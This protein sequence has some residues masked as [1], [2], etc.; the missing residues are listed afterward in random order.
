M[1][2]NESNSRDLE[3]DEVK[4]FSQEG[5]CFIF[6]SVNGVI[7]SVE[8]KSDKIIRIRYAPESVFERD[9]SYAIDD[10]FEGQL[11]EL[12]FKEKDDH[13]RITTERLIVRI[14]KDDLGVK[15]LDKSGTTISEDE[16]GFH[17][18]ANPTHGGNIVKMSKFIQPSE[19]FYGLG[20]KTGRLNLRNARYE[21]WGT[22]CYAYGKNSD[23][24]YKNI[25]FYYGLHQ[26]LSYGIFFDNS[27]RS[28]FDF[29]K[30]RNNV[31]SF[32]AEGGEM[33]Y[34]FIYGP[35][36]MEVAE[37]YARLT[38]CPEMP[39]LWA[40]GYHQ[41]KWSYYPESKVREIA[42]EFR[43]RSIPCDA[44]YL[45]IDYMD[46]FRCFTWDKEK[47][48]DPKKMISDLEKDGFKTVV[49]IDPGIKVD[50]DYFVCQEGL[51]NDYFCRRGDGPLMKGYV[52]PGPCYFPDYT[53]ASVRSWWADLYEDM[54]VDKGVKGVWNDMN[55]PALFIEDNFTQSDRTFPSDVRHDFDG[56][57][58][59]HRKG[60]NVYGMQMVRA[61]HEGLKKHMYPN[62]PFV[63]TRSCYAGTQRYSS[64]WTGDNVATWEHLW[65]ANIQCQRLAVSGLSFIGSD[66]GG[67]IEQPT[68]ELYARWIQLGIFH[69]FCRTHSSGDHGDQE[70]W[71]F[72]E[73]YV[74]IVRKFIE[75]RYQLLPHLYTAF[76][77]NVQYGTPILRPIAFLDQKD[78]DVYHRMGEFGFGDHILVCPIIQAN[79]DGRWLYVP[80]GTWFYY[81]DNAKVEGGV[82]IW[83]DADMDRIP[84]YVKAGAVIPFFPVMQYVG[85][86]V[87]E[88][89]TLNVYHKNGTET[90]QFYADAGD[91]YGHLEGD[92][93]L[94]NFTLTG[95]EEELVLEQ[96][97]IGGYTPTFPTYAL[98]LNG[99]PFEISQIL[100]DGEEVEWNKNE[101][102]KPT[103]VCQIPSG[104]SNLTMKG[105]KKEQ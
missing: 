24:L 2:H 36:L 39:P 60:H 62:R 51:E 4:S 20:D 30:E 87:V 45:D 92:Y 15:F 31:T 82:E 46:G 59:T 14:S 41:C 91:G 98:Q 1:N 23:P 84:M 63:I 21:L 11:D 10:A 66:I 71:V 104:F 69:P 97:I 50:P 5:N 56:D 68:G 26:G 53:K 7:L 105:I 38:G 49:M 102:E 80:K 35:K 42:S 67:F 32:W 96:K 99:L 54:I 73:E 37:A 88:E 93:R 6:T 72:D 12:K 47:F 25:P 19:Y 27:F 18:E 34:Y 33:N 43:K 57:P 40:L 22:D 29:G 3:P 100:V 70:P 94:A 77:Q 103:V 8:P 86:R 76:W 79:A 48:P 101:N 78:T 58:S 74:D 9:F 65:I 81:W 44:I 90:S 61:T 55:E 85:E 75:L 17:W 28:S 64:A 13:F 83:A 52:W 95:N 89:V 16:K